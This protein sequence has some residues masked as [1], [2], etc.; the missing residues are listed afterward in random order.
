M[1]VKCN[2]KKKAFTIRLYPKPNE[3]IVKQGEVIALS[4]NSGSSGGPHLHYEIRDVK[5]NILNPMLF[6]INVPDHKNPTIQ[7][8]FAYSKNGRFPGESIIK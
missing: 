2:T 4:G 3:L 8:A 5:S 1:C 6:G 7:N